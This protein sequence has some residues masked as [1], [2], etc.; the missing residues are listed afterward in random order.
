MARKSAHE[1]APSR[2]KALAKISSSPHRYKS[3]RPA[4]LG[5]RHK[6]HKH[7][8]KREVT[9]RSRDLPD[10]LRHNWD[11]QQGRANSHSSSASLCISL[12]WCCHTAA[13]EEAGHVQRGTVHLLL[14]L[15]RILQKR[16][17]SGSWGA[18]HEG[19]VSVSPSCPC[20][21]S[22][23]AALWLV[24]PC[25][26]HAPSGQEGWDECPAQLPLEPWRTWRTAAFHQ[27]LIFSTGSVTFLLTSPRSWAGEQG[28]ATP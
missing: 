17:I 11:S 1:R 12:P 6:K 19:T 20:D 15:H 9:K 18:G 16:S 26:L 10:R 8:L 25:W 22:C 5:N 13:S 28:T 4:F 27:L 3:A 21:A 7:V 14:R 23:H 24:S 2:P